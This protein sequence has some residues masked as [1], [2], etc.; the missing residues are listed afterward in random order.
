MARTKRFL[1][2]LT[3]LSA[4]FLPAAEAFAGRGTN[5]SETLLAD[6]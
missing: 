4:S 2:A 5:H 1:I 3:V 6:D